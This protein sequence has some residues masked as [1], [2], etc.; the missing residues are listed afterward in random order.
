MPVIS[1]ERTS[2]QLDGCTISYQRGGTGAPLLF[3]HGASNV[4]GW[5][6]FMEGLA[7]RHDVIV[8]DH[9]GF[10]RSE[11]PKWLD[12]IHDLAYFYLDF[13]AKLGLEGV[14][15]VGGSLGGWIACEIAIRQTTPLKSLTLVAP[16]GLRLDGHRK[17]DTFLLSPEALTRALF[18]DQRLADAAIAQEPTEESTEIQFKNRY[19]FARVAWQP[20][21]FDPHLS[22]WLHRIDVPTLV[23]WGDSD[24]LIPPVYAAEFARLIPGAQTEIIPNCGHLPQVE[25]P[26]QFLAAVT[27]FI[28]TKGA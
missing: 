22:K 18:F 1:P 11:I 27:R 6:P 5:L 25:R 16:A 10:G 19:S 2:I 23:L 7:E 24:R 3:L 13:I 12:N 26:D 14:H 8:P 28:E 4:A 17:L 20:R 21:L 15:L 9:P